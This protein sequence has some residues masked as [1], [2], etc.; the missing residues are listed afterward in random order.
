MFTSSASIVAMPCGHYLHKACYTRYMETAYKCPICKKSA[1]NMELQWRKLEQA[2]ES[3][4]M[5]REFRDTKIIIQ[6]NDCS[7]KSSVRYHWLGNQCSTCDSFN[8]NELQLLGPGSEEVQRNTTGHQLQGIEPLP[9]SIQMEDPDAAP[10]R[11]QPVRSRTEPGAVPR[12][13]S[14]LLPGSYFLS[15]QDSTSDTSV[16]RT[17]I[18]QNIP[19]SPL[20]MF[21]RVSRSLSPIRHY[22]IAGSDYDDEDDGTAID[23][24]EDVD[25]WGEDGG[26]FLS[27][28]EE[29]SDEDDED[30]DS[31]EVS[32][33][34][35]ESEDEDGGMAQRLDG[36]GHVRRELDDL[37]DLIGHR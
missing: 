36:H 17:S 10:I 16:R 34:A 28:E 27:G 25:F 9:P 8:T 15:I 18:A 30:E 32:E 37:D 7:A 12:F 14:R 20:E 21:H 23:D 19:F 13:D 29:D 4:P 24:S 2:I 33:D 6:C 22:L 11:L 35:A 5:P 3:Q 26:R 31:D 1:V